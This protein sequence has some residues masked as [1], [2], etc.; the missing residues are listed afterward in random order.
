M[1]WHA[2]TSTAPHAGSGRSVRWWMMAR[3]AQTHP[4]RRL[5]CRS[6]LNQPR[7]GS[8]RV[9]PPVPHDGVQSG[10][11]AEQERDSEHALPRL[12][13]CRMT[14]SCFVPAPRPLQGSPA[15]GDSHASLLGGEGATPP[16]GPS[17]HRPPRCVT[18]FKH[19]QLRHRSRWSPCAH[20]AARASGSSH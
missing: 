10:R 7:T 2:P 14:A 5:S 16:R 11:A 8:V 19:H 4:A 12:L 17:N 3:G 13:S 1:S 20:S 9:V 18:E 6:W 15:P